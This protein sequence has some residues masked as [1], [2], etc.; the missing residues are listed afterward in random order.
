VTLCWTHTDP[1]EM[2]NGLPATK[3]FIRIPDYQFVAFEVK[4]IKV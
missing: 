1:I 3:Y 2:T 4:G